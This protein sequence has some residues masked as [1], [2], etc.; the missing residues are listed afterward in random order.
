MRAR[1]VILAI[2]IMIVTAMVRELKPMSLKRQMMSILLWTDNGLPGTK[3][4][5]EVTPGIIWSHVPKT[6]TQFATTLALAS[7]LYVVTLW[8]NL[9]GTGA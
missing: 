1:V 9:K 3:P 4:F 6:G 2:L 5:T 7:S 8:K